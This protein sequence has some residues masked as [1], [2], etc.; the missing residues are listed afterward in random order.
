MNN[1]LPYIPGSISYIAVIWLIILYHKSIKKCFWKGNIS[2][3]K[4]RAMTILLNPAFVFFSIILIIVP[5]SSYVLDI[6]IYKNFFDHKNSVLAA[7]YSGMVISTLLYVLLTFWISGFFGKKLEVKNNECITFVIMMYSVA[8]SMLLRSDTTKGATIGYIIDTF[9]YIAL[10]IACYLLYHF[11]IPPLSKLTDK[12]SVINKKLFIAPTT[13]FMIIYNNIT[14]VSM[15]FADIIPFYLIITF[16]IIIFYLFIWAFYIIIVNVN[17]NNEALDAQKTIAEMAKV[18]ARIEADLS[19]AKNIQNSA[20]PRIFPAFPEKKEFE[21][22]ASMQAAKE[23]GGDF[24]DFYMLNDNT[25]GFL[26][27]DVS[28]KSIPGAMFMMTAKTIIKSLAESG[29]QPNEVFTQANN[30]L[31]EGNEAEM[32]VTAWL[33]YLDLKTGV[34]H[35]ANAGHNPPLMLHNGK[36]D[37]IILKPGLML[38]GMEDINY[39]EQTVQ[40][41]KGDI[42]Y[43]YTDG[44]TEAMNTNEKLYGEERLQKILTFGNN[45]P[46]PT[47]ENGTV[48]SI[49]KLVSKDIEE[50]SSGAEQSDDI[51]MLCIRYLG[52]A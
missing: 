36:A 15:N 14:L 18:E 21:L 47:A 29:L 12:Q 35:V 30:K 16:S 33:G 20:L 6:A 4:L 22:F 13:I 9:G 8:L 52:G 46:E 37:Y 10:I 49:C 44:V 40:M 48:E 23:V 26:I 7:S 43:L 1:I 42:I 50:Y 34:I 3:R 31:C 27:A 19:V 11:I 25:L 17:A 38:A 5:L 32:F 28:G 24:Y 41:Q 39:K 2:K 45:Y 51:T